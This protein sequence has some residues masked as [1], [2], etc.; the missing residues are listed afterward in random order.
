MTTLKNHTGD[1]G[2]AM[3]PSYGVIDKAQR[4]EVLTVGSMHRMARHVRACGVLRLKTI[5]RAQRNFV[6][7]K[8]LAGLRLTAFT[9]Q[10]A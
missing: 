6:R 2:N 3:L 9:M 7:L 8:C 5:C 10:S 1:A 4:K